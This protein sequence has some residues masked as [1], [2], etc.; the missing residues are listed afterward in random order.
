MFLQNDVKKK[1][2]Y[3][4][5]TAG[6]GIIDVILKSWTEVHLLTH[7]LKNLEMFLSKMFLLF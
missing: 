2:K 1:I 5:K 7:P 3:L 6:D 4:C